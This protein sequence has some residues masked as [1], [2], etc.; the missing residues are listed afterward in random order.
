M[1]HI[2]RRYVFF[3]IGLFVNSL[4]VAFITRAD[5]GTSP[6]SSIPYVLSLNFSFT[7]GQYTMIFSAFLVLLQILILRKDYQPV[8]LLQLLVGVLF[9]YFI[10]FSMD[11]LL[12]WLNPE[13]YAAK[14]VYLLIGCA[15][16]GFGVFMEVAANALMLP[17]EGLANAIH[18]K[19]GRAFGTTK[20]CVDVSF[21]VCAAIL[22]LVFAH[23]IAGVREGTII[24]A[25]LVGNLSRFYGKLMKPVTD[26]LFPETDSAKDNVVSKSDAE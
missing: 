24:S 8:Q 16:L 7:L 9:G 13:Q 26:K 20:V 3:L 25:L 23:R 11:V 10:D 15:I 12:I 14:M 19:S 5:L 2:V 21:I 4:G 18:R 22:S 6:I 17:G 1:N